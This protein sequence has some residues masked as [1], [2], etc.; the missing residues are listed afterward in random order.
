VVRRQ[1]I[2]DLAERIN[3][4]GC[5]GRWP[6]AQHEWWRELDTCASLAGPNA[7]DATFAPND[8]TKAIA[9]GQDATSGAGTAWYSIDSGVSWQLA[10]FSGGISG[11]GRIEI[12]YARSNPAIV[13]ALVDCNNGCTIILRCCLCLFW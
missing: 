11:A 10:T 5:H 12:A 9:S 13:Y 7:Q 8:N 6:G 4:P 2:S 3:H 1:P